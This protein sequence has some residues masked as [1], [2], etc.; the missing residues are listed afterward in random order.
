M[1]DIVLSPVM[2]GSLINFVYTVLI[3]SVREDF[4]AAVA[5]ANSLATATI[6]VSWCLIH[7]DRPYKEV[8]LRV[9]YHDMSTTP[10][11]HHEDSPLLEPFGSTCI[12]LGHDGYSSEI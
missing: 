2:A 7:Q 1:A 10:S 12:E 5:P 4:I 8:S 6:A 9:S 11:H 3:F